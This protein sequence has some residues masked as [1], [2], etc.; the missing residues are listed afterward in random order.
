[1]EGFETKHLIVRQDSTIF[2]RLQ[3][4]EWLRQWLHKSRTTSVQFT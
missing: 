1:M 3:K 2:A 4:P